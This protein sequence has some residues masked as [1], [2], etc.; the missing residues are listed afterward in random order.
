MTANKF[1]LLFNLV[2]LGTIMLSVNQQAEAMPQIESPV[3]VEVQL[4][5]V[6]LDTVSTT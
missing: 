3:P 6:D 5:L 1:R 2:V 4:F